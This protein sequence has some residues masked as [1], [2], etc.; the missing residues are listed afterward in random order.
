[1]VILCE[2]LGSTIK[3]ESTSNSKSILDTNKAIRNS[4]IAR[5][6]DRDAGQ[7]VVLIALGAGR[8]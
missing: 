4:G 3:T 7:K 1:V 6:T 8:S 5:R 2:V